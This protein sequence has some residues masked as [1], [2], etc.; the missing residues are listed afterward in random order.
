MKWRP[1]WGS[2]IDQEMTE[3]LVCSCTK[4]GG[5]RSVMM[6]LMNEAEG[7]L[8]AETMD[9]QRLEIIAELLDEKLELV[10]SLDE[11]IIETC[12]VEEIEDEMVESDELNSRATKIWRMIRN[13]HCGSN[14]LR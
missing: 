13:F 1:K 3:K 7:L 8:K 6:K 10:K 12:K 5:N 4:H 14:N 2:D 11:E 9:K